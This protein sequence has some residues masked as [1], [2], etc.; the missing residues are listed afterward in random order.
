MWNEI[1]HIF[2]YI[3]EF[4]MVS[5]TIRLVLSVFLGGIIGME[6]A[7][8]RSAA[9]LRTFALVSLGSSLAMITNQYL[10][11]TSGIT[12]DPSRMAAQVISGIGFL[13]VGTIIVTGRNHVK[14]LTTAAS[15]W[16]T[17]TMGIA[18]GSGFIYGGLVTFILIMVSVRL[19][20]FISKRQEDFNRIITM[21]V[22]IDKENGFDGFMNYLKDQDYVLL[23]IEK[24][25]QKALLDK[26]FVVITEFDL[27]NRRSHQE[28]VEEVRHIDGVHYVEEL[29]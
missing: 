10:L 2:N 8:K 3:E 7:T 6:R 27:K 16:T 17:A 11:V 9:G 22:E 23:S 25:K 5:I 1:V 26:D 14:G 12:G 15:L 21:Y 24:K 4:N 29:K 13:G 19:L 28:I 20:L 18:I